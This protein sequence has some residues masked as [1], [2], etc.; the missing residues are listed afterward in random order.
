MDLLVAI[1]QK[2][3]VNQL[4]KC[5][6]ECPSDEVT[7]P[8]A[9]Q[10]LK[11]LL[12][13]RGFD[14][15]AAFAALDAD[16]SGS[17][18]HEE[19]RDG[20][21]TLGIDLPNSQ[22][23]ELIA[24]FDEDGDGNIEY[25][26]FVREFGAKPEDLLRTLT[27]LQSKLVAV[28][29]DF[30]EEDLT[31]AFSA[32]DF[33][34]DGSITHDEF[35]AGLRRLGIVLPT[36]TV[37]QLLKAFDA[38]NDGEINYVEFLRE[39]GTKPH[40]L[41]AMLK[42]RGLSDMKQG[43]QA[44]DKDGDGSISHEEFRE[45]LQALGVSLPVNQIE[46]LIKTLDADLDG[47]ID[48]DEFVR[49]IPRGS[50][51][52]SSAI[53]LLQKK[54]DKRANAMKGSRAVRMLISA[55]NRGPGDRARL[56][57][58]E[59]K[60]T[61]LIIASAAELRTAHV[62]HSF[63]ATEWFADA[64]ATGATSLYDQSKQ[65]PGQGIVY[66]K[67]L[68]VEAIFAVSQ[69]AQLDVCQELLLKKTIIPSLLSLKLSMGFRDGAGSVAA[70]L[71]GQIFCSLCRNKS[72]RDK[73]EEEYG[74][75]VLVPILYASQDDGGTTEM[76]MWALRA[77]GVD[78]A[79][80]STSMLARGGLKY[81][82]DE[83]VFND[84]LPCASRLVQTAADPS[85]R[86]FAMCVLSVLSHDE[87]LLEVLATGEGNMD[88]VIKYAVGSTDPLGCREVARLLRNI[89]RRDDLKEAAAHTMPVVTVLAWMGKHD[90]I[91]ATFAREVL[92]AYTATKAS[93]YMVAQRRARLVEALAEGGLAIPA[94]L[95]MASFLVDAGQHKAEHLVRER[96][97]EVANRKRKIK[98]AWERVEEANA[99]I[100]KLQKARPQTKT[101]T[102]VRTLALQGRIDDMIGQL[103]FKVAKLMQDARIVEEQ[104]EREQEKEKAKA[105]DAASQQVHILFKKYDKDMS[106]ELDEKELALLLAD[107]GHTGVTRVGLG[108]KIQEAYRGMIHDIMKSIDIDGDGTCSV[109]ELTEW[110]LQRE[111]VGTLSDGQIED[112]DL[113][114][115]CVSQLVELV[116]KTSADAKAVAP[117]EGAPKT[118]EQKDAARRNKWSQSLTNARRLLGVGSMVKD[119]TIKSQMS[120]K[121]DNIKGAAQRIKQTLG[122]LQMQTVEGVFLAWSD[123]V[124]VM[125]KKKLPRYK[126][127]RVTSIRVGEALTSMK[128]GQLHEG[129]EIDVMEKKPL[130]LGVQRLKCELG[131]VSDKLISGGVCLEEITYTKTVKSSSKFQKDLVVSERAK[132][133]VGTLTITVVEAK[134]LPK[135]D[136]FGSV[137]PFTLVKCGQ[138]QF[139]TPTVR[140]NRAPKWGTK[141]K[142]PKVTLESQVA[143]EV[144]DHDLAGSDDLMG[145]LKINVRDLSKTRSVYRSTVDSWYALQSAPSIRDEFQCEL[146][147]K[148]EF[149]SDRVHDE[150]TYK[151]A[152]IT[153]EPDRFVLTTEPPPWSMMAVE[154]VPLLVVNDMSI[155]TAM[156][157]FLRFLVEI[158][159][160]RNAIVDHPW[161][162]NNL[163]VL[164]STFHPPIKRDCTHALVTLTREVPGMADR[165][166]HKLKWSAVTPLLGLES[167]DTIIGAARLLTEVVLNVNPAVR[168]NTIEGMVRAID[169]EHLETNLRR[170]KYTQMFT[171]DG[172][173]AARLEDAPELAL[174]TLALLSTVITPHGKARAEWC[175]SE[176]AC[177]L[178]VWLIEKGSTRMQRA[179]SHLVAQL[180]ANF[181]CQATLYENGLQH[182][183]HRPIKEKKPYDRW[184]VEEKPD[185]ES[186]SR[187]FFLDDSD[188]DQRTKCYL[189]CIA[190]RLGCTPQNQNAWI[191]ANGLAMLNELLDLRDREVNASCALLLSCLSS[192]GK[193]TVTK[194]GVR[195]LTEKASDVLVPL[196]RLC[197]INDPQ[198]RQY[199]NA[200]V[201]QLSIKLDDLS[202]LVELGGIPV[203]FPM[204]LTSS[205]RTQAWAAA[206]LAKS[207]EN[208]G[209]HE[210]FI[211]ESNHMAVLKCARTTAVSKTRINLEDC[212]SRVCED[213][214][215]RDTAFAIGTYY[216]LQ[217]LARYDSHIVWAA[218][219]LFELSESRDADAEV[220]RHVCGMQGG[221]SAIPVLC[222]NRYF[223]DEESTAKHTS[224]ALANFAA[225]PSFHA[226]LLKAGAAGPIVLLVQHPNETVRTKACEALVS[227]TAADKA[228]RTGLEEHVNLKDMKSMLASEHEN[229]VISTM[230]AVSRLTIT[231]LLQMQCTN[232]GFFGAILSAVTK[233]PAAR[234]SA[235][236]LLC[237][238][239][240]C[241]EARIKCSE[242]QLWQPLLACRISSD[243]SQRLWSIKVLVKIFNKTTRTELLPLLQNDYCME[244]IMEAFKFNDQSSISATIRALGRLVASCVVAIDSANLGGD[245]PKFQTI[246]EAEQTHSFL[247]TSN[248][249]GA[250]DKLLTSFA[251]IR[252]V[253]YIYPT[254]SS[255]Y[256]EEV[257]DDNICMEV[258]NLIS[259]VASSSNSIY[260]AT[261]LSSAAPIASQQAD[262][263]VPIQVWDGR[264]QVAHTS[265]RPIPERDPWEWRK[266]DGSVIGCSNRSNPWH[267]C[268]SFCAQVLK[269]GVKRR[270]RLTDRPEIP[271]KPTTLK[272][273]ETILRLYTIFQNTKS[274]DFVSAIA[275]QQQFALQLSALRTLCS[276]C[277]SDA[278]RNAVTAL[279]DLDEMITECTET[280]VT[281]RLS[282]FK[283]LL[284]VGRSETNT[285]ALLTSV[286][287]K[288]LVRLSRKALGRARVVLDELFGVLASSFD[289][290]SA[291]KMRDIVEK[292]LKQCDFALKR[293]LNEV[294][295]AVEKVETAPNPTKIKAME[296]LKAQTEDFVVEKDAAA[297]EFDAWHSD[298]HMF[299]SIDVCWAVLRDQKSDMSVRAWYLN[300]LAMLSHDKENQWARGLD[301][302]LVAGTE[303][304]DAESVSALLQLANTNEKTVQADFASIMLHLAKDKNNHG[305][306][307]VAHSVPVLAAICESPPA[308]RTAAKNV[309]ESL[310]FLLH[311]FAVMKYFEGRADAYQ[312]IILVSQLFA[313]DQVVQRWG[314]EL[315]AKAPNP[316]KVTLQILSE[317][318]SNLE[319]ELNALEALSVAR[320][321]GVRSNCASRVNAL[322]LANPKVRAQFCHA[323]GLRTIR[324]LLKSTESNILILALEALRALADDSTCRDPIL[325]KQLDLLDAVAAHL[326]TSEDEL[327]VL[328]I[329]ILAGISA[330]D[331]DAQDDMQLYLKNLPVCAEIGS[332][333]SIVSV[334]GPQNGDAVGDNQ[335]AGANQSQ[336]RDEIEIDLAKR[337]KAS[338]NR[339]QHVMNALLK[340]IDNGCWRVLLRSSGANPPRAL[341]SG[342][343]AA[344]RL[345]CA[346]APTK[347][348]RELLETDKSFY[349]LV[350]YIE[351]GDDHDLKHQCNQW[352]AI[353][354]AQQD[355][356]PPLAEE[357]EKQAASA[358]SQAM[359]AKGLIHLIRPIGSDDVKL[360]LQCLNALNIQLQDGFA[361]KECV[362]LPLLIQLQQCVKFRHPATRVYVCNLFNLLS[363]DKAFERRLSRKGYFNSVAAMCAET[364]HPQ[365]DALSQKLGREVI[366]RLLQREDAREAAVHGNALAAFAFAI[367][368]GDTQLQRWCLISLV[369]LAKVVL[370]KAKQIQR[371]KAKAAIERKKMLIKITKVDQLVVEEEAWNESMTDSY[372]NLVLPLLSDETTDD[373]VQAFAVQ[374]VRYLCQAQTQTFR[375]IGVQVFETILHLL[376][377]SAIQTQIE[378]CRAV[379]VLVEHG[380]TAIS[381]DEFTSMDVYSQHLVGMTMVPYI[382]VD[383]LN[384]IPSVMQSWLGG[385][386]QDAIHHESDKADNFGVA[387]QE[388]RSGTKKNPHVLLLAVA[389]PLLES[390]ES[391][392]RIA[393]LS[394][395]RSLAAKYP[396]FRIRMYLHDILPSIMRIAL[397]AG[398]EMVFRHKA[399]SEER[400]L[401]RNILCHL[402]ADEVSRK[403]LVHGWHTSGVLLIVQAYEAVMMGIIE[404]DA[405]LRKHKAWLARALT[406]LA[407]TDANSRRPIAKKALTVLL[408][409]SASSDTE[410]RHAAVRCIATVLSSKID[411]E[412]TAFH[413]ESVTKELLRHLHIQGDDNLQRRI[414]T[415]LVGLLRDVRYTSVKPEDSNIR[416]LLL[417][418]RAGSVDEKVWVSDTLVSLAEDH[419]NWSTATSKLTLE[420]LA[421]LIQTNEETLQVQAGKTLE[422]LVTDQRK[423][424]LLT[425]S[426]GLLL[427]A[428]L[429]MSNIISVH[430]S[431]LKA[432]V[433]LSASPGSQA[434]ILASGIPQLLA[435][436]L[437]VWYT[438]MIT[439][440][441][442]AVF[443][444]NHDGPNHDGVQH[445][446]SHKPSDEI[447]AMPAVD[448]AL[449]QKA[450]T[451]F[452]IN[453]KT[454]FSKV[455]GAIRMASLTQITPQPDQGQQPQLTVAQPLLEAD[456]ALSGDRQQIGT[457]DEETKCALEES[458]IQKTKSNTQ[459]DENISVE[460]KGNTRSV[461]L[462]DS[463]TQSH[464]SGAAD[465]ER[466]IGET[467]SI[468]GD[469]ES[470]SESKSQ[471]ESKPQAESNPQTESKPSSISS[472]TLALKSALSPQN[473]TLGPKKHLGSQN[474]SVKSALWKSAKS[475]S[476]KA[477]L[478][479]TLTK[480]AAESRGREQAEI[481]NL[482]CQVL[483]N[484]LSSSTCD[485]VRD[486]IE[487]Q[488]LAALG[489]TTLITWLHTNVD[490]YDH[491]ARQAIVSVKGSRWW[492][493]GD[494]NSRGIVKQF[495][496]PYPEI[497]KPMVMKSIAF[498]SKHT[499]AVS[500]CGA[501]FVSG[502]NSHGQL[503]VKKTQL[504]AFARLDALKDVD[505]ASIGCGVTFSAAVS[506]DGCLWTWGCN[507]KGQCGHGF[508]SAKVEVPQLLPTSISVLQATGGL[509]HG[510]L[511]DVKG[512]IWT[513]GE[514]AQGQ[515]GHGDI[516]P[517]LTPTKVSAADEFVHIGCGPSYNVGLT[518]NGKV[519]TWGDNTEGQL[520]FPQ[521]HNGCLPA[522]V[523]LMADEIVTDVAVG[524]AH[525]IALTVLGTA[526]SWGDNT[527]GQLGRK[528]AEGCS[529]NFDGAPQRV[530]LHELPMLRRVDTGAVN[531]EEPQELRYTERVVSVACGDDHTVLVTNAGIAYSF[532]QGSCGQQGRL[533]T[534]SAFTPRLM[535]TLLADQH[536]VGAFCANNGTVLVAVPSMNNTTE[537]NPAAFAAAT[538]DEYLTDLRVLAKIL[539]VSLFPRNRIERQLAAD[540]V[541]L[542]DRVH[543]ITEMHSKLPKFPVEGGGAEPAVVPPPSAPPATAASLFSKLVDLELESEATVQPMRHQLS[544]GK[545]DLQHYVNLF[546]SKIHEAEERRRLKEEQERL[547]RE[548]DP[549]ENFVDAYSEYVEACLSI[550][551]RAGMY[552]D[553][554][555]DIPSAEHLW[556]TFRRYDSYALGLLSQDFVSD[557]ARQGAA[558]RALAG[559]NITRLIA[560]NLIGRE[561]ETLIATLPSCTP[562][563]A[564]LFFA[565]VQ[566]ALSQLGRAWHGDAVVSGHEYYGQMWRDRVPGNIALLN[567]ISLPMQRASL[568]FEM[569][570]KAHQEETLREGLRWTENVP[571]AKKP[572]V[573]EVTLD[574]E[575]STVDDEF[576]AKFCADVAAGLDIPPR[577][578]KVIRVVAGSV[579]VTCVVLPG[580]SKSEPPAE[581]LIDRLKTKAADNHS[582]LRRGSVTKSV[583]GIKALPIPELSEDLLPTVIT[584]MKPFAKKAEGGSKFGFGRRKKK[585]DAARSLES[586]QMEYAI[587][588]FAT[589]QNIEHALDELVTSADTDPSRCSKVLIV[590]GDTLGARIIDI[591][592]FQ[593][594]FQIET[595]L[596]EK[597]KKKEPAKRARRKKQKPNAHKILVPLF[598]V[599]LFMSL[600]FVLILSDDKAAGI[601]SLTGYSGLV[602][603]AFVS[604]TLYRSYK[605]STLS[606]P[607]YKKGGVNAKLDPN[608]SNMMAAFALVAEFAQ[609]NALALAVAL[610]WSDAMTQPLDAVLL[611]GGRDNGLSSAILAAAVVLL[612]WPVSLHAVLGRI[613]S[614][615]QVV[616]IVLCTIIP[617]LVTELLFVPI[618]LSLAAIIPCNRHWMSSKTSC[619]QPDFLAVSSLSLVAGVTFSLSATLTPVHLYYVRSDLQIRQQHWCRMAMLYCKCMLVTCSVTL[620]G[621]DVAPG[622]TVAVSVLGNLLLVLLSLRG[623]PKRT[624]SLVAAAPFNIFRTLSF[625]LAA[626]SSGCLLFTGEGHGQYLL[627]ASNIEGPSSTEMSDASEWRNNIAAASTVLPVST[628]GSSAGA[629][630]PV[631]IDGS[632]DD[633]DGSNAD[634]APNG[635]ATLDNEPSLI[636]TA[637]AWE[638]VM[639]RVGIGWA[640]VIM[641]MLLVHL[642]NRR[643]RT[644]SSKYVVPIKGAGSL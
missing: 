466:G 246:T 643:R 16:K 259:Y 166:L 448:P 115:F 324:A 266:G 527:D 515:L 19:F 201:W 138:T 194:D 347:T 178:M 346:V 469:A 406:E 460:T 644:G 548:G 637:T 588:K 285:A 233:F 25:R 79:G 375:R 147:L 502:D 394:L 351:H 1:E 571:L 500:L 172:R 369:E 152:A 226:R 628:D 76:H 205:H 155:R 496:T 437:D 421:A 368:S 355:M 568:Y 40:Q 235:L 540:I 621:H 370:Q 472:T 381:T 200:T 371:K 98:E 480:S 244:M 338:Q 358:T 128:I 21:R 254:I 443:G 265:R 7:N 164:F 596:P 491:P 119:N 586:K 250:I 599:G 230:T 416:S 474:L 433:A 111:G 344:R 395:M 580:T 169:F 52:V 417:L 342:Q 278:E 157:S 436:T 186:L 545:H 467:V 330:G 110:Y 499:L 440:R 389:A 51:E 140:N 627:S 105:R 287:M 477:V 315:L 590:I 304:I 468:G 168:D 189:G 62:L 507:T 39:F 93:K 486:C 490:K 175:R 215:R 384:A 314:S 297:A 489:R 420:A 187:I 567:L 340:S 27:K 579:K 72:L 445:L 53:S 148:C 237:N 512:R 544:S 120:T 462:N 270:P 55:L 537:L 82:V 286:Y 356:R 58:E 42:E 570:R 488:S 185:E 149:L 339:A 29:A 606:L 83:I 600:F 91:M 45:G 249:M 514:G 311:N 8:G 594:I 107:L 289:H 133:D 575:F 167:P 357:D 313:D 61:C 582:I 543:T 551:D 268:S 559:E 261:E 106:G 492:N 24:V 552:L 90:E 451:D 483:R 282:F 209:V 242:N 11:T 131:W 506:R 202:G 465:A 638:A 118:E 572:A 271:T 453:I 260:S 332:S 13:E 463:I 302:D 397:A 497:P 103:E 554:P 36:T 221:F 529:D 449:R 153:N 524:R 481:L 561:L 290:S 239:C 604:A 299:R 354:A 191:R 144:Y 255:T 331:K 256:E 184:A 104:V 335:L 214:I 560:E 145:S 66:P 94:T 566:H 274:R 458:R 576:E 428:G 636:S 431:G 352:L 112:A 4:A 597:W 538:Q 320:D 190:C 591:A 484:L 212:I 263:L 10:Q 151:K 513:W 581:D 301:V 532:G 413:T 20:L 615:L 553:N 459:N 439:S 30:T 275:E 34:G 536:V 50:L 533:D 624:G 241:S 427:L 631:V 211:T 557:W 225:K 577:R 505:V 35:R 162:M 441:F 329:G 519:V 206:Y 129:D 539:P 382:D 279:C 264:K 22:I 411:R 207:V 267:T 308:D 224:T 401:A 641:A 234:D 430:V 425:N 399:V 626:W 158:Q 522:R 593:K 412:A 405:N 232:L 385:K 402:C 327:K 154:V 623:G 49:E 257:Y 217:I 192:A 374:V 136:L 438:S 592:A 134:G 589:S 101:D 204:L 86:R 343:S 208:E 603:T 17:I 408:H 534:L 523:D 528:V 563:P 362:G 550:M 316:A 359:V 625:A 156:A 323:G 222:S 391:E 454:A 46:Q 456:G 291:L 193:L 252:G 70:R 614:R 139:R 85:V 549:F 236:H 280:N 530:F 177:R 54:L 622:W 92:I 142:F 531:V 640:V 429:A 48:Y 616:E 573:A 269:D 392:A 309:K 203:V 159:E 360:R 243:D 377:S 44:L 99:E 446:R 41:H 493:L 68:S 410:V 564:T 337:R 328:C 32:L 471:A 303:R 386:F 74:L 31:T 135:M 479:S 423:H 122:R 387:S 376:D 183:V 109:E 310:R 247:A 213:P 558:E 96:N 253:S 238:M 365:T 75:P 97:V 516:R 305:H 383:A 635:V 601:S 80:G 396:Q 198:I 487:S 366:L 71:I 629:H 100:K 63:G 174:P 353:N 108:N 9:A 15:S 404:D 556:P 611:W 373:T 509:T 89:V 584:I 565:S 227:I 78:G 37:E 349:S 165:I 470:Q 498:G 415:T 378:C 6:R 102:N 307:V 546:Q 296:D 64:L 326:G 400:D 434:P 248:M 447:E 65:S 197:D 608:G 146:H 188:L 312:M 632:S 562:R 435:S 322:C 130:G 393:A 240:R 295:A 277:R 504:S 218:K 424:V 605:H 125:R 363:K 161:G 57:R 163:L 273:V 321:A 127:L 457:N 620:P 380:H 442:Q 607:A 276:M 137:D 535:T 639:L 318:Y 409:L 14:L 450:A 494:I 196:G 403:A 511:L 521:D 517:R 526:Y 495:P 132:R 81:T 379:D 33:D 160:A 633:H 634:D 348:G 60:I 619:D 578:L 220:A 171:R 390:L 372:S 251:Y 18:T 542:V 419:M 26:E 520:G 219:Q 262:Q 56:S 555:T 642:R 181:D 2:A 618:M 306:I 617:W 121:L 414:D 602:L 325:Q 228:I 170:S 609:H 367:N 508:L 123:Y 77:T 88:G 444:P 426:G 113:A 95:A 585:V 569:L 272:S 210:Y 478:L 407:T 126:C 199:S 452:H 334:G 292:N 23:R 595:Y 432:L 574:L 179:A 5:L 283:L 116:Q 541:N 476:K 418:A 612:I 525:V 245:Y 422:K 195:Q 317:D 67:P 117:A 300:R 231:P 298:M 473:M 482:T 87:H 69:L 281:L 38:D 73:I 630:T 12:S 150:D 114:R 350:C 398:N 288:K 223:N 59:V 47:E 598:S 475:A 510:A 319:E 501:T 182:L 455:R 84:L 229:V 216:T 294:A 613:T 610:N 547:D 336:I 485:C 503:G 176:E 141:F 341:A 124:A 388:D 583:V 284:E 180:A 3:P 28:D 293:H 143:L 461:I 464:P 333:R 587:T 258:M 43:F 345:I 518:K 361:R 173:P 364:G